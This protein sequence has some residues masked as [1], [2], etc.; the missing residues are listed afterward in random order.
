MKKLLNIFSLA[1]I[2]AFGFAACE[3]EKASPIELDLE[4]LSFRWIDGE[5]KAI[6]VTS[7]A[8]F[9]ATP[10]DPWIH[11]SV[12]GNIVTVTL[13]ALP[14][15]D[16]PGRS[17]SVV[18]DNGSEQ[19]AV[20]IT[21]NPALLS[22]K[23]EGKW[24]SSQYFAY[25][26]EI[27]KENG[28][29]AVA[30]EQMRVVTISY[31]DETTVKISDFMGLAH[32]FEDGTTEQDTVF[33]TVDNENGTISIASQKLT[34]TFDGQ[35]YDTYF[36]RILN[37]Y[38]NYPDGK[39]YNNWGVGFDNI[40]VILEHPETGN[41]VIDLWSGGFDMGPLY[42]VTTYGSIVILSKDDVIPYKAY[43]YTTYTT[44]TWWEKLP[45]DYVPPTST[46][47]IASEKPRLS[48]LR[49]EFEL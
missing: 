25:P 2:V 48:E 16:S 15:Q 6:T 1:V 46:R 24:A 49:R 39:L 41:M 27:L 10:S 36:C 33:A 22:D 5:E 3:K 9:N 45:D 17:G 31:V 42:D 37:D 21:Q 20:S 40:P 14:T 34:P 32:Y 38:I 47:N 4:V 19:V 13:D 12:S 11:A 30:P 35:G 8:K 7:A 43:W 18:I 26:V 28:M 44:D 23:L 29:A